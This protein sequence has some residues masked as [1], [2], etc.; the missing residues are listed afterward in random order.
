[1]PQGQ[2]NIPGVLVF[3]TDDMIIS[4]TPPT[5]WPLVPTNI[6]EVGENFRI[7]ASFKGEGFVWNWLKTANAPFEIKYFAESM[8][9]GT[10]NALLG[11]K[12]GNLTASDT[13]GPPETEF[14]VVNTLAEGVYRVTCLVKF[15]NHPHLTGYFMMNDLLE[16]YSA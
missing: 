8:G 9:P 1:M 13:Y 5:I 11:V 15:P 7:A 10:D 12:N 3:K 16:V 6:V 4:T 14:T 2:P